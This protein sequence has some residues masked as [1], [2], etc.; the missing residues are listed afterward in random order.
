MTDQQYLEMCRIEDKYTKSPSV[1]E[2]SQAFKE[3]RN[4]LMPLRSIVAKELKSIYSKWIKL[5][6]FNVNFM[7][8]DER[9]KIIQELDKF[10]AFTKENKSDSNER[11]TDE[12]I[13][14]AK[15]VPIES[16]YSFKRKGNKIFCP[17]HD[18]FNNPSA[19]IYD[20]KFHCFTCGINFDTIEFIKNI[21]GISFVE[22]VK[23]LNNK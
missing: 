19:T 16:L 14:C 22:A 21:N 9:Y 2:L 7:K 11:I 23:I 4:E 17:F 1:Y 20:N 5:H 18:D 10:L 6:H 13:Q 3:N 8:I 12:D 15:L